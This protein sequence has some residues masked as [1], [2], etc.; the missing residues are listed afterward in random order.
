MDT[1][2]DMLA[3]GVNVVCAQCEDRRG[4]LAVAWAT[5]T[6]VD[7]VLICVGQQSWTRELI[8][9]SGAFG[10]S[11]LADDQLDVARCF[12]TQS[13]R[14]VDKFEGLDWH[15]GDTG[16]PLLD[17]CIVALDCVV[18]NSYDEGSTKLIVGQV[19]KAEYLKTAKTPLIYRQD[20]Y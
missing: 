16:S 5:Q 11:L 9:T 12:G 3:H 18:E 10:L 2:Y 4:G 13:S 14:D 1:R 15:T 7:R 6:A 17:D 20:D 19:V 8:L